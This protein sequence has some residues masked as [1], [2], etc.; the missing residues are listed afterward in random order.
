MLTTK[1]LL[2]ASAAFAAFGMMAAN[3]QA[4][5]VAPVLDKTLLLDDFGGDGLDTGDSGSVNG[6]F[7]T[8]GDTGSYTITEQ[9]SDSTALLSTD[10]SGTA[11]GLVSNSPIDTSQIFT[12]QW[13]IGKID[14]FPGNSEG[15]R[16][17]LS[18]DSTGE[19][20]PDIFIDWGREV[21]ISA[22][23]QTIIANDLQKTDEAKTASWVRATIDSTGY[24]FE[25]SAGSDVTGAWDADVFDA[26]SDTNGMSY[27]TAG[28]RD[29]ST[30][31]K[32]TS[33]VEFDTIQ[34][35]TIPEPAAA[36]LIGV[37]GLLMLRRRSRG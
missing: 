28:F 10:D 26:L 8:F 1:H 24:L 27:V 11:A 15:Y 6:G 7:G 36:A 18:D 20:D 17:G 22:A 13:D 23:G 9:P 30:K 29:R 4:A 16:V 33:F 21:E 19:F 35:T 25:F 34:V 5:P 2:T 12:V 31:N 37:G 3:S 32:P 14:S